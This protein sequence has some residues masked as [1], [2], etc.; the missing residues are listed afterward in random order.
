MTASPDFTA[1][2]ADWVQSRMAKLKAADGWLNIVGRWWLTPGAPVTLG[3]GAGHD[4]TLDAGPEDLGR[5]TLN[6]DDTASFEPAAGGAPVALDLKAGQSRWHADRFLLEITSINDLRS[7]RIRDTESDAAAGLAA[8]PRFPLD[9]ALRIRARW[10]AL[11][12]P[13]SLTLD[14]IVGIPTQVPVTHVAHLQLG[15]HDMSLLPTYGSAD[16]PQFVLRDLTSLDDTYAKARFV[17]GEEVTADSVV[18]DFNRAINPPCAFTPYAICPLP[19]RENLF[20]VRI[21]AGER[22]VA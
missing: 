19:P 13:I 6:P 17:F 11:P 4:V 10:E 8:I 2:H 18:I 1:A 22:R 7:L 3:R 20:P 16:R 9:P 12:Q 5:L 21:E 15:G 14:T